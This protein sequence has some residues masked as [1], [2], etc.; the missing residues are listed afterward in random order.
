MLKS[1]SHFYIFRALLFSIYIM[2]LFWGC[3]PQNTNIPRSKNEKTEEKINIQ[4]G[5]KLLTTMQE[6]TIVKKG[7]EIASLG[8]GCFWCIEAVFDEL[9]GVEKSISGYMG[10]AKENPTYKEVCYGNTGHAEIINVYFDPSVISYEDILRVF[11]HVHD[12]TTLNRQGND[13][14]TQYRSAIFYYDDAQ[15]A[16]AKKIIDEIEKSN[17]W[18]NKIVTEVTNFARFYPA[19]DYHQEYFKLNGHAPYCQY[20]IAPK[21]KKFRTEFKDRLKNSG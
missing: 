6:D 5:K 20:I 21:M 3:T 16:S 1:N 7:L 2:P 18:N 9:Q 8:G 13:I 17:L 4:E 11:F 10:G 19:E 15:K 14:G 12:P